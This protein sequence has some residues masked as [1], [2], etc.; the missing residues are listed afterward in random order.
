[1]SQMKLDDERRLLECKGRTVALLAKEYALLRCLYD[2]ANRVFSREHLLD[3]VW[4]GEYPTDR[5]VD[6]HVYR[7]RRKLKEVGGPAIETVRGVGYS[8]SLP[9]RLALAEVSLRDPAVQ[10]AMNG[11][12]ARYHRIGQGQAILKLANQQQEL[13]FELDSFYR[14]YIRFI[15]GDLRWFLETHEPPM[16]ERIYWLLLFYLF[17]DTPDP[18]AAVCERALRLNAMHAEGEREMRLL[19]IA[20]LYA[21]EGRMEEAKAVLSE[22]QR[23][24]VEQ[25]LDGFVMALG[26]SALYMSLLDGDADTARKQSVDVAELLKAEPY[27]RELAAY[28]MLEGVRQLLDSGGQSGE[29]M[30]REGL[31]IFEQSGFIP[32]RLLALKRV[33]EV[34]RQRLPGYP[35]ERRYSLKFT[36]ES[37]RLGLHDLQPKLES[38]I[39]AYLDQLESDQVFL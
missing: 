36:E 5:T 37:I 11:V 2:N 20:D 4:P 1:M 13:G 8:L 17:A 6:D 34:L 28:R 26:T 19:N 24:A 10:E 18:K 3:R 7:L 15:Q 9:P 35:V 33:G 39:R 29:E 38:K 30:L 27:L 22:G 12:F 25:G 31:E 23:T 21:N 14:L 32:H 16:N